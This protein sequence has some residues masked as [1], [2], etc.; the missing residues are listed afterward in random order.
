MKRYID[1]RWYIDGREVEQLEYCTKAEELEEQYSENLII[2]TEI[3]WTSLLWKQ[4]T[5]YFDCQFNHLAY[6]VEFKEYL[7]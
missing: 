5:N 2:K 4:E 6:L 3:E 7:E 1:R